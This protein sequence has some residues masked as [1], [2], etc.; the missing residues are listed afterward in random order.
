MIKDFQ[1]KSFYISRSGFPVMAINVAK[2]GFDCREE[3][4]VYT[5]LTD[6]FDTPRGEVWVMY[7]PEFLR[8]FSPMTE[9]LNGELIRRVPLVVLGSHI[10]TYGFLAKNTHNEDQLLDFIATGEH[11]GRLVSSAD[12]VSQ[13]DVSEHHDFVL[14]NLLYKEYDHAEFGEWG[15]LSGDLVV[16]LGTNPAMEAILDT[17]LPVLANYFT[18]VQL[19]IGETTAN[20]KN[21]IAKMHAPFLLSE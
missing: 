14:R 18:S 2:N 15:V 12:G 1:P 6:T 7:K 5:N 8:I 10:A 4:V 19:E 11:R 17:S 20:G 21:T 16:K 9:T 3:S 13:I